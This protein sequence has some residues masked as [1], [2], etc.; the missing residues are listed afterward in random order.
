MSALPGRSPVG[1]AR[2]SAKL[3]HVLYATRKAHHA[4]PGARLIHGLQRPRSDD[5][6]GRT[7]PVCQPGTGRPPGHMGTGSPDA[8]R[9]RGIRESADRPYSVGPLL[10]R[11]CHRAGL[12]W[13]DSSWLS[14][15]PVR[16]G[17]LEVA[18]RSVGYSPPPE[19]LN[20]CGRAG[21]DPESGET[22]TTGRLI[23][24]LLDS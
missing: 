22:G 9:P 7:D 18:E 6:N 11:G 13:T 17:D 1:T 8:A 2:D 12:P 21:A 4:A 3:N 24:L 5:V 19:D 15:H 23:L 16:V 10:G 14:P 20:G